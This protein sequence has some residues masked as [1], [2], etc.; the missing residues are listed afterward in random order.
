MILGLLSTPDFEEALKNG[1]CKEFINWKWNEVKI[2]DLI[3]CLPTALFLIF[4]LLNL[5]ISWRKLVETESLIMSTYYGFLW[6]VCLYNLARC[7]FLYFFP[8]PTVLH[9][10][11]YLISNFV[12]IFVEIS[13]VVFMSHGHMVSGREALTRTVLITGIIT[14]LY[15]VVQ[16]ILTFGLGIELFPMDEGASSLFWLIS[17]AVFTMTYT[18]II[19]LPKTS[20]RD[21]LPARPS[22]YHYVSFLLSL[23]L[24][25]AF[26]ATLV[27][28][29]MDGGFCFVDLA[30]FGYYSLYAPLLYFCFLREF[31]KEVVLPDAFMEMSKSGFLDSDT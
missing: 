19:V 20:L 14:S 28:S 21:R 4:L 22:F 24:M 1:W 16:A 27:Y 7:L 8:G 23:N 30:M 29:G 11:L 13:V 5:R 15:S 17:C 9:N 18:I 10:I 2:F 26:G 31:F 6:C 12:L 3:L 25:E